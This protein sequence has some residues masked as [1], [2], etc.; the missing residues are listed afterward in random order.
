MALDQ[1]KLKDSVKDIILN[2]PGDNAQAATA[3]AAAVLDFAADAE[4]LY[5]GPPVSLPQP[6]PAALT[7]PKPSSIK[8]T[9]LPLEAG[10]GLMEPL[11][12]ASFDA[13]DP[14][15]LGM[16]LAVSAFIGSLSLPGAWK[17][18]SP[19][20]PIPIATVP[21]GVAAPGFYTPFLVGGMAISKTLPEEP[22]D[23]DKDAMAEKI[24]GLFAKIT[25]AAFKTST[26][27]AAIPAPTGQVYPLVGT[28]K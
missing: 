22:T 8:I 13:G 11:L 28:I 4:I 1:N 3:W 7:L 19:Y 21:T 17:I 15:F 2:M 6:T 20:S 10:P 27:A 24:A 16:Q 14:T 23:E 12:K 18:S 5:P 25:L 9:S 26:C